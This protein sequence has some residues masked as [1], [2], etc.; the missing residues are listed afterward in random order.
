MDGKYIQ[1]FKKGSLEMMLL[2]LI[3]RKETYGYEDL[4]EFYEYLEQYAEK[5]CYEEMLLYYIQRRENLEVTDEYYEKKVLE[6]AEPYDIKEFAEAESFL[7]YYYGAEE[8]NKM[9]LH[10]YTQSWL[11]ENATVM[12]DIHQIYSPELNK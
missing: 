10:M 12:E 4:D 6:M 11:A 8:L 9:L 1:Q 7:V 2:C 5:T 3:S